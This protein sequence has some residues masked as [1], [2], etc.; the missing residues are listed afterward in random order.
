M[1]PRSSSLN[2]AKSLLAHRVLLDVDLQALAAL[3][4]VREPGLAHATQRHHASGDAHPRLRG[5][6]FFGRLGAVLRQNLRDGV[7]ELEPL[8]VGRIA[9]RFDFADPRQ[10]L[11]EQVVFEGQMVSYGK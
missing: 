10:A 8:A 2:S 11:F 3:L 4:Q 1:S 6:E 7:R 9:Q 5:L